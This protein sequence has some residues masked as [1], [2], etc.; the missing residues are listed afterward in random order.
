MILDPPSLNAQLLLVSVQIEIIMVVQ[1]DYDK[2]G[3]RLEAQT[4]ADLTIGDT[5]IQ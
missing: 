5:H 4:S 3:R 1:R 2:H